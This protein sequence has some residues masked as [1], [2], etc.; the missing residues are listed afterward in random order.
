MRQT[1]VS[2][3]GLIA[4]VLL[5]ALAAPRRR[6]LA[7]AVCGALTA[8]TA[9]AFGLATPPGPLA[10]ARERRRFA[11]AAV[12]RTPGMVQVLTVG[13]LMVTSLTCVLTFPCRRRAI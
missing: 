11:P 5:P 9:L 3:G 8:A 7:L 10:A 4:A 12:L 6:P 1:A 2:V 13:V